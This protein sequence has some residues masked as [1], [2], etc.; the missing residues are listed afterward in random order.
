MEQKQAII[1][2]YADFSLPSAEPD[3]ILN[4]P[5]GDSVKFFLFPMSALCKCREG[6]L[7]QSYIVSRSADSGRR[8]G[9]AA[10]IFSDK[11]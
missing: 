7:L 6:G 5:T 8:R 2:V 10:I 4:R 3:H 9:R 1:F 11:I